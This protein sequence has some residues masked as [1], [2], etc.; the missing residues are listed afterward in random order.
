[1]PKPP[2]TRRASKDT[3][4]WERIFSKQHFG[5]SRRALMQKISPAVVTS[6]S[7]FRNSHAAVFDRIRNGSIEVI[8]HRGEPFVLLGQNQLLSLMGKTEG[9]RTAA[10]LLD[11]LP[12]V[13]SDG[14]IPRAQSILSKSHHRVPPQ[15]DK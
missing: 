3:S 9:R 10:E 2:I 1:M 14:H 6:I 8:T 4:E 12:S 13:A 15:K 7:V 11:G 5:D